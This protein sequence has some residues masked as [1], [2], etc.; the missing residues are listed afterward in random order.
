MINLQE[1][2]NYFEIKGWKNENEI[3]GFNTRMTD[4]HAAIG[5]SQLR[6][7]ESWTAERRK[8]ASFFDENLRNVI[9]P[10]VLP[11]TTHVYHQYTIKVVDLDRDKF[12]D[13]LKKRGVGSGV[14]YPI[15]VHKL[16]S[17][18]LNND[19]PATELVCKQV[20]SI[21]VYPSLTQNELE[22]I[23]DAVNAVAKFG[24]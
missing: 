6:K 1:L 24:S 7:I 14:Y 20:L 4:L 21:P 15:P 23:V 12:A 10:Y 17:F 22:E 9:T 13:E 5:R 3:V 11:N 19:L 18:N 16:S 2:V 8:N